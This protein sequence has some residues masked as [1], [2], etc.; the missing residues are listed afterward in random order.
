MRPWELLPERSRFGLRGDGGTASSGDGS[1]LYDGVKLVLT[2]RLKLASC[3][4]MFAV[5]EIEMISEV[6]GYTCKCTVVT[7]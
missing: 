3:S 4:A 6:S 1:I 5:Y 7:S 2:V